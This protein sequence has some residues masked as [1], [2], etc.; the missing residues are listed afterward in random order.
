MSQMAAVKTTI[1]KTDT[2]SLVMQMFDDAFSLLQ[3][4]NFLF[5]TPPVIRHRP[6]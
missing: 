1:G 3:C 2:F 5:L 4:D 6:L